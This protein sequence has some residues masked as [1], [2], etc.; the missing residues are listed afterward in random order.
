MPRWDCECQDCGSVREMTARNLDELKRT[1]TCDVCGY[2]M[3]P[4][5]SK[6]AVIVNGFNAKNGYSK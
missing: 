4:L 3:D 6:A 5:P 2:A 1:A